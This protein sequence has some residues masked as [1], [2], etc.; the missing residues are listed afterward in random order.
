MRF[1]HAWTRAAVTAAITV[2]GLGFAV[3]TASADNNYDETWCWTK[4]DGSHVD[5][6][7][8][9][10]DFMSAT[11]YVNGYCSDGR[12]IDYTWRLEGN[13][14]ASDWFDC[15]PDARPYNWS[16]EA[17]TMRERHERNWAF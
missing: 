12:E 11:V 8:T 10:E 13:S 5:L 15:G 17:L 3:G 14:T 1:T 4:A 6:E 7:C 2:S 9:N 16:A